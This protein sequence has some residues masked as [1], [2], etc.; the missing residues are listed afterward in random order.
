[1]SQVL[2]TESYLDDIADAIREKNG[3]EDTYTPA[4]MAGAIEDIH[5]ADDVVLV[6]KSITANGTYNPASD[7]A[8]GYSG[9]TVSVPNS[10]SASDE[11]KVV[12]SGELVSQSS[13]TKTENGTYDTTLNNEIVIAVPSP[14]LVQKTITKNGTYNP[15]SDNA[16]GY[17][18]IVVNVSDGGEGNVQFFGYSDV[19]FKNTVNDTNIGNAQTNKITT[20]ITNPSG[21]EQI[22]YTTAP[23]DLT[24]KNRVFIIF[25][26]CQ[27]NTNVTYGGIVL[28]VKSTIPTSYSDA[29]TNAVSKSIASAQD[30]IV[31]DVSNLTGSYY[32]YYASKIYFSNSGY[33]RATFNIY[34]I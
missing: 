27:L 9:V 3:S 10:Y 26:N 21:T 13:A 11:G 30:A 2:V 6:N 34:A 12:S 5:T 16:D 22:I 7:S 8:D 32:L 17:S 14:V 28:G 18:S 24:D 1:M 33:A 4:Q 23:I 15:A 31:L 19:T 20:E 29:K 25:D